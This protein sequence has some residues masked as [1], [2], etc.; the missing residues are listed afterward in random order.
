M[1]LLFS[2]HIIN[3]INSKGLSPTVIF[4]QCYLRTFLF[5]GCMTPQ[6]N[7]SNPLQDENNITYLYSKGNG[8]PEIES[9]STSSMN[10][11]FPPFT[12]ETIQTSNNNIESTTHKMRKILKH[13][14]KKPIHLQDENENN[15]QDVLVEFID[16]KKGLFS[17]DELTDAMNSNE[18]LMNDFT[19][20]TS[21]DVN[22][23]YKETLE[24]N[25]FGNIFNGDYEN[26][27]DGIKDN[28]AKTKRDHQYLE[29]RYLIRTK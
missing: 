9:L 15:K 17:K 29:G 20:T 14:Y 12:T 11:L 4:G 7:W 19:A 3:F 18:N 8:M 5:S 23:E 2:K 22:E 13:I 10:E 1:K 28:D 25:D 6:S 27:V 26:S 16:S 24:G 21:G